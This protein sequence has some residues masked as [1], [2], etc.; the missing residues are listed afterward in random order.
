MQLE[1]ELNKSTLGSGKNAMYELLE[2][3]AS[4]QLRFPLHCTDEK[5]EVA[6]MKS[7]LIEYRACA[8]NAKSVAASAFNSG[9]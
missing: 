3:T 7:L 4:I 2:K 8:A 9:S 1:E 6:F 5:L